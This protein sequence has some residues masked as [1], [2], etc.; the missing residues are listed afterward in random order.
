MNDATENEIWEQ[1]HFHTPSTSHIHTRHRRIHLISI[2]S[3]WMIHFVFA[4]TA[5]FEPRTRHS[6]VKCPMLRPESMWSPCTAHRAMC[7][8]HTHT[9]TFHALNKQNIQKTT[10]T[11][12]FYRHSVCT[13]DSVVRGQSECIK[14]IRFPMPNAHTNHAG[15]AIISIFIENCS[16]SSR[17]HNIPI[18]TYSSVI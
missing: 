7:T 4:Y 8:V 16:R 13:R 3:N 14:S 15:I 11:Y 6:A 10:I 2:T 1:S 18:Y 9:H 17:S 12:L 5:Q